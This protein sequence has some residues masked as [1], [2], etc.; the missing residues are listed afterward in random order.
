MFL[1]GDIYSTIERLLPGNKPSCVYMVILV[2]YSMD[3]LITGYKGIIST[4]AV[5]CLVS[6]LHMEIF[7]ARSH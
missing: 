7:I 1:Y 5:I 6:Y 4:I 2:L 3:P